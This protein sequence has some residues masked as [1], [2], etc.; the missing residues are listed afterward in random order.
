MSAADNQRPD[1]SPTMTGA[2]LLRWYWLKSE[3]ISLARMLGLA[4]TG[5]KEELTTRLAAVL[6]GHPPP[7]RQRAF[8]ASDDQLVGNLSA[9]TVIPPG[10]RSSQR[11]RAWF[12]RQVG[13]SFRFDR[14]MRDFV[15][16]AD[17]STTLGD[18]LNH[19][20]STRN[21]PATEIDAQ[22]E[23]NRFTRAWHETNPSGTRAELLADWR[24]HRSLPLD[25]RDRA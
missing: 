11:L 16:A 10:Q 17:G 13:P 18:A 19:W 22:F 1:L 4:S 7:R 2:E 6:D 25:V 9:S 5:S 12:Q 15:R 23:F 14:H 8:H 20:K 3:L 24:H 21:Q